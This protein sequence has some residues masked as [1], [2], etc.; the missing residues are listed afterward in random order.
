MPSPD[1]FGR[2]VTLDA[3]G[4]Q[5]A[6]AAMRPQSCTGTPPGCPRGMHTRMMQLT[7]CAACFLLPT[8]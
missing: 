3:M 8:A 6:I 2:V 7:Y 4:G 1:T 5:T